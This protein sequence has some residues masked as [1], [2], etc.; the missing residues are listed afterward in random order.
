M[1]SPTQDLI[2]VL[3]LDRGEWEAGVGPGGARGVREV[4]HTAVNYL[5]SP[6][7]E[8]GLLCSSLPACSHACAHIFFSSY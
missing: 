8:L 5:W 6:L 2:E 1:T 7:H 4:L 3:K